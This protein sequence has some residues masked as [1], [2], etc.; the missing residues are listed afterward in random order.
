MDPPPG[1]PIDEGGYASYYRSPLHY[2]PLTWNCR[3][4]RAS[5]N[6]DSRWHQKVYRL[7]GE[8]IA[9]TIIILPLL[10]LQGGMLAAHVRAWRE[11]RKGRSWF[12]QRLGSEDETAR[13]GE[14]SE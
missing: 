1:P 11:Q 10:I 14:G 12:Q 13:E 3:L 9:A 2:N 7:C 4:E 8:G 6:R 5:S